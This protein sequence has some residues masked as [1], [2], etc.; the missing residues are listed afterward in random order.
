MRALGAPPAPR[1]FA[2][3]DENA[4]AGLLGPHGF[5]L[6]LSE[7]ALTYT[8]PSARAWLNGESENHPLSVAGRAVL[9]RSGEAEAAY[10]RALAVL[11]AANEASPSF[12][13]TSRYVVAAAHRR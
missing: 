8:A 3:H 5:T 13:V 1:G 11:E 7:E 12:R 4:L 2:W 10:E 9:E 6:T